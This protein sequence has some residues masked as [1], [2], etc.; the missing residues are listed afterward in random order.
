MMKLEAINIKEPLGQLYF[1]FQEAMLEY[2]SYNRIK[3][4]E[5]ATRILC[6]HLSVEERAVT[7][8]GHIPHNFIEFRKGSYWQRQ[9]ATPAYDNQG[10]PLLIPGSIATSS[11]VLAPGPNAEK[12]GESVLHGAGRVLSRKK[13]KETLEQTALDK[14]FEECGVMGSFRHVPLDEA[15]AAYKDVDEVIKA[16]VTLGVA[17][18]VKR[19]RPVL[20]FKGE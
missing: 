7:F 20:V 10:I 4:E 19:L 1:M 9:G 5:V 16:V 17:K 18:V 11:Y 12:Y 15:S 14:Q 13:A 6:N 2:A 8:L 3:I